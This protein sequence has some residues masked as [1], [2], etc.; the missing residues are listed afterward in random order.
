MLDWRRLAKEDVLFE[1]LRAKMLDLD[2]SWVRRISI[3]RRKEMHLERVTHGKKRGRRNEPSALV[4]QI[5]RRAHFML[6]QWTSFLLTTRNPI[7]IYHFPLVRGS[8]FTRDGKER[9]KLLRNRLSR[10]D[11]QDD[12]RLGK[13]RL[14]STHNDWMRHSISS[15]LGKLIFASWRT[16]TYSADHISLS[17]L[18]SAT[19]FPRS[20]AAS[21]SL[22][23]KET[24]LDGTIYTIYFSLVVAT[25]TTEQVTGISFRQ[26]VVR[27]G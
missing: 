15:K 23:S 21:D 27:Q 1:D 9:I 25:T 10:F 26:R 5:C 16:E 22:R 13:F 12:F 6:I 8:N 18:W 17:A 11:A 14:E 7:L 4:W 19:L 20:A 3:R 24:Q 2:S